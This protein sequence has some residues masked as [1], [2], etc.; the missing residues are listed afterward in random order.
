MSVRPPARNLSIYMYVHHYYW[1]LAYVDL[2]RL[3]ANVSRLNIRNQS[4]VSDVETLH[5]G[6]GIVT[7][8][9]ITFPDQ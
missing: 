5:L 8:N 9:Q 6:H 4:F 2:S 3:I 7:A 1:L